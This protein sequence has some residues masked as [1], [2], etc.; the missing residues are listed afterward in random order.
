MDMHFDTP[1][2]KHKEW[3]GAE[4]WKDQIAINKKLSMVILESFASYQFK[5]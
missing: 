4:N 5:I 2:Q 3:Q 1:A